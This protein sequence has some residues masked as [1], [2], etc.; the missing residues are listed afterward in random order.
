M[1]KVAFFEN[2]YFDATPQITK[3]LETPNSKEIRICMAK[4]NIM[5]EHT[6]PGA[7]TIMVLRGEVT[8]GSNDKNITLQD[9]EMIYFDAKIPHSL[10]AIEQN[11]LRLVLSKN[12]TVQRVQNLVRL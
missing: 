10:E 4:G 11:I 8:I 3:M 5:K 12:D 7:I 1:T 9:G 6:A 2:L